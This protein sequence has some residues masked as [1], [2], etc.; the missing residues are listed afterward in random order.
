MDG[1]QTW[2]SAS[3]ERPAALADQLVRTVYQTVHFD[4][5]I[6]ARQR[7]KQNYALENCQLSAQDAALTKATAAVI[8]VSGLVFLVTLSPRPTHAGCRVPGAMGE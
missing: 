5:D 1:R 3:E 7:A 2:L 8:T 6:T 4:R